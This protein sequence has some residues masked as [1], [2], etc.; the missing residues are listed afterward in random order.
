M[1]SLD[2]LLYLAGVSSDYLD[3]EGRHCEVAREDRLRALRAMGF[4][5]DDA[6]AVAN[7]LRA[8]DAEPW[9]ELLRP[10]YIL[11]TGKVAIAIQV[12]PELLE[13]TLHWQ[14]ATE[15]GETRSGSCRPARLA[16]AGEYWLDGVRYS[17]HHLPLGELAPGYHTL[18][19]DDGA[20]KWQARLVACPER[21]YEIPGE[22]RLWGI[23]CQLYTLRSERNWGVGDFTDLRDLVSRLASLGADLVGLNPLHAPC[24]DSPLAPSPYSPSDRRFLNPVYLDPERMPEWQALV[25]AG[26]EL[27][28]AER[29][30]R[31]KQLHD[32]PEVDYEGINA[33][34]YEL[35][36]ALYAQFLAEHAT[37]DTPRAREFAAFT[38]EEGDALQYFGHYEMEHNGY[39]RQF[40]NDPGFFV[41]LQWQAREQLAACQQAAR[42]AGMRVGL[43]RDLAVGAVQQGA[44]IAED[45]TLYVPGATVGAPPDPLGPLGQ[46]WG[47][48]A[49]NPLTLRQQQFAHFIELL[50]RNMD[51]AGALRIDHVMAVMRL[52]WCFPESADGPRTGMY[53]Y[54]PMEEM[55]SLLRLESQR[56]QCLVVGE[57]LGVVPAE[58]REEMHRSHIYGN[59]LLYFDTHL[60]GR[61]RLPWEQAGDTLTMVTNHDVPT[62]ADWWDCSDLERRHDLGLMSGPEEL[63]AARESR[64]H[65]KGRLLD[66]LRDSGVPREGEALP[67]PARPLDLGGCSLIHRASARGRTRLL[68][69]QL[70]DLQL[71]REPVNIPGT[72]LE[73]PNWRRKQARNTAEVLDDPE[74]IELL[75]AVDQERKA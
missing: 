35:F 37:S 6:K 21:A 46:D 52:W 59:R 75:T 47:L 40:A 25:A 54:Y 50:R 63:A 5:T 8:I 22:S 62:L 20:H 55:L 17:A 74:I 29:L 7:A 36:E 26:V 67:D 30:A 28:T 61:H 12:P 60:D 44:E 3:Y 45:P 14:L 39:A 73:Y 11:P 48:P 9:M 53:V 16:E 72:W 71:M 19:V 10:C 18:S 66:W 2:K 24:S 68:L 13:A 15:Q 1:D 58:L 27:Q 34:K 32:C 56:Q 65:A 64:A 31:R 43:V 49:M 33:L 69:L 38:E 23:G 57:D 41:Y 51:A 70:E 4:D 42:D